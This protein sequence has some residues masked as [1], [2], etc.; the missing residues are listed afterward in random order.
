MKT[1]ILFLF[2]PFLK[3]ARTNYHGSITNKSTIQ[4]VPFATVGLKNLIFK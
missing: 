4:I 3:T 2:I 1:L